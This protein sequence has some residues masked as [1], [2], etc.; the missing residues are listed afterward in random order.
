MLGFRLMLFTIKWY[1]R[2]DIFKKQL[3]FIVFNPLMHNVP[4]WSDTLYKSFSIC[5]KIFEN[6][7]DHFGTLF[8][9]GLKEKYFII[10][11]PP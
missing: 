1:S 6:V 4:K 3:L 10:N 5:T 8:M 7:S 11:Y 9:T 2:K